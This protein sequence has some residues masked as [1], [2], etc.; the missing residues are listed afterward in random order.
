MLGK[1]NGTDYNTE[2]V[3]QTGGSSDGPPVY[4]D[5][6]E[7]IPSTTAGCGVSSTETATHRV[8]N[9]LLLFDSATQEHATVSFAWPAGWAT[10]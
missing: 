8:Q 4:K 1:I 7:F 3:D 6:A 2:W 9:D 5:A 10:V